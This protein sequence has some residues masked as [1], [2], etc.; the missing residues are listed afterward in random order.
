YISTGSLYLCSM[1]FLPLGLP[2][3]NA[4]WAEPAADWTS[5]KIWNGVNVPADHAMSL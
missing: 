1:A 2:S 5:K 4:F 3:N